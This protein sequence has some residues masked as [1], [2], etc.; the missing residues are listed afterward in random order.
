MLGGASS[1]KKLR[2]EQPMSKGKGVNTSGMI[3]RGLER[4]VVR[5]FAPEEDV[6]ESPE[7]TPR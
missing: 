2:M 1:S 3:H 4:E 7:V 6:V 5:E